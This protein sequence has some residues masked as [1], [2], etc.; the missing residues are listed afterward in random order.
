MMTVADWVVL[1][2]V[3]G[4]FF[5]ALLLGMAVARDTQPD[6]GELDEARD[7]ASHWKRYALDLATEAYVKGIQLED[8]KRRNRHLVALPDDI[9]SGNRDHSLRVVEP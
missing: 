2:A 8:I 6:P 4:G 9:L 5:A 1:A 3:A 7:D